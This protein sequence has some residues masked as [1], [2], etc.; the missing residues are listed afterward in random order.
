MNGLREWTDIALIA[1]G[2]VYKWVL[3]AL[4]VAAVILGGLFAAGVFTGEDDAAETVT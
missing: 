4:A 2:A 3:G 1:M